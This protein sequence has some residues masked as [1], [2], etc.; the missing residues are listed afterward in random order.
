MANMQQIEV[1]VGE[2]DPIAGTPPLLDSRAELY[3]AQ[4][5]GV[6]IQ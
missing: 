1:T 2:R 3:A 6:P 4:D 5:F